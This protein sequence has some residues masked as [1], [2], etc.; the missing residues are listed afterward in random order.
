[1]NLQL[2]EKHVYMMKD[3]DLSK[4]G[5]MSQMLKEKYVYVMKDK[6]LSNNVLM[7]RVSKEKMM[8][9]RF[10][11]TITRSFAWLCMKPNL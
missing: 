7:I 9:L 6:D 11:F 1:M 8:V 3:K 5:P 2:T 4:D 10:H